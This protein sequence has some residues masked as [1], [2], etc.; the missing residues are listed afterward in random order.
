MSG[1]KKQRVG[2]AL[3]LAGR[4][5]LFICDEPVSA[6]DVSAQAAVINL[7]LEIQ[8]GVGFFPKCCKS[9]RA[10]RGKAILGFIV[11]DLSVA[12]YFSDDIAVMHLGQIVEIGPAE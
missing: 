7:L 5:D 3:T 1:G 12:R 10:F 6:P 2:I 9:R 4:P 8:Q 11:H